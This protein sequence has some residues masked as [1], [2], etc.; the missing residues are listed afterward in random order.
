M[1][2]P[3]GVVILGQSIAWAAVESV[4]RQSPKIDI[5][6]IT[7]PEQWSNLS[8]LGVDIVL[9]D[10][11]ELSFYIE[12][13]R[14]RLPHGLALMGLNFNNSNMTMHLSHKDDLKTVRELVQILQQNAQYGI[15]APESSTAEP[16]LR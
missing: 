16:R 1:N 6:K 15:D 10:E 9:F 7:A 8:T 3:L 14:R 2:Y 11:G 13:L 5:I 12:K 4:L